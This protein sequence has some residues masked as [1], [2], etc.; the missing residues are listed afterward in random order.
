MILISSAS[1]ITFSTIIH[2]NG[3]FKVLSPPPNG[4]LLYELCR[5]AK[6]PR[7]AI[8]FFYRKVQYSGRP[9]KFWNHIFLDLTNTCKALIVFGQ[10]LVEI[11]LFLFHYYYYFYFSGGKKNIN[12]NKVIFCNKSILKDPSVNH[13]RMLLFMNLKGA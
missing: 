13:L 6:L 2:C 4:F 12:F 8:F 10:R 1:N 7:K 5:W 3:K 11:N 9:S